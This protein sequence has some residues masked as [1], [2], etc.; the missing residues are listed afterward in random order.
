MAWRGWPT[1]PRTSPTA[2]AR[3]TAALPPPLRRRR[4]HP[5]LRRPPRGVRGNDGP[6]LRH[7]LLPTRNWPLLLS[8]APDGASDGRAG[9]TLA[10]CARTTAASAPSDSPAA[11][12]DRGGTAAPPSCG[13]SL[14]AL[15]PFPLQ[16]FLLPLPDHR[17]A[18]RRGCL[19]VPRPPLPCGPLAPPVPQLVPASTFT[20]TMTTTSTS[21]L[22]HSD[23]DY[24]HGGHRDCAHYHDDVLPPA[25]RPL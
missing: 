1:G 8:R 22:A 4:C 17:G 19:R 16:P 5:L 18:V 6:T 3:A 15:R 9:V 11:F 2:P 10:S 20:S 13:L 7:R 23:S 21:P 24:N 12:L 14:S 25:P